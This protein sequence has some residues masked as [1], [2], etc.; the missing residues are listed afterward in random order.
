MQYSYIFDTV[1]KLCEAQYL[2]F[3]LLEDNSLNCESFNALGG[4]VFDLALFSVY[5]VHL[6][7]MH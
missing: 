3:F 5:L 1:Y 6:L 7:L 2:W 4:S